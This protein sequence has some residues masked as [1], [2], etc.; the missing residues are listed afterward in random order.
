MRESPLPDQDLKAKQSHE[1]GIWRS[2]TQRQLVDVSLAA[3][4][5][6]WEARRLRDKV[7]RN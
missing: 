3:S 5:G 7:S 2:Q 6:P 1:G 4:I